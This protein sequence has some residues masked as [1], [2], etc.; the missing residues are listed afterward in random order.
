VGTGKVHTFW[1]GI[2]GERANIEDIGID[3][4]II[5]K[6]ISKKLVG[7][8]GLDYSGL[9]YGEA[10]DTCEHGNKMSGCVI[11]EEFFQYLKNCQLLFSM[12]QTQCKR[13]DLCRGRWYL[14]SAVTTI[15]SFVA[16]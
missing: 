10:A 3:G 9:E 5:F 4:K 7:K 8:S 1:W 15:S 2:L 13:M 16:L 6:L 14:V 12:S 11:C